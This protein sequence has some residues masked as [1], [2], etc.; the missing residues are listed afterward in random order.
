VTRSYDG[1]G[2]RLIIPKSGGGIFQDLTN[3][4]DGISPGPSSNIRTQTIA[5]QRDLRTFCDE[6]VAIGDL[7]KCVN[8][9]NVLRGECD[10]RCKQPHAGDQVGRCEQ[11]ADGVF[12]IVA[13]ECGVKTLVP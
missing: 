8:T 13:E 1:P 12:E 11:F 4:V 10:H 2:W 6:R 7:V 5:Y 9:A 3:L